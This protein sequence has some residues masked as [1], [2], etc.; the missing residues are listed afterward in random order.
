M[1]KNI[2]KKIHESTKEMHDG[3]SLG[4]FSF[5][6]HFVCFVLFFVVVVLFFL[7]AR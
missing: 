3:T 6:F 7:V 4:G 1:T 2:M 5:V